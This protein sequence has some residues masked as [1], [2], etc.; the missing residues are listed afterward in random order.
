MLDEAPVEL[1]EGALV[2]VSPEGP[3]YSWVITVARPASSVLTIA[4]GGKRDVDGLPNQGGHG[5]TTQPGHPREPATLLRREQ[6]LQPL[7]CHT[8][9]LPTSRLTQSYIY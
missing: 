1:L 3:F 7:Q 9:R 8:Q 5:L 6:D 2:E 4:F